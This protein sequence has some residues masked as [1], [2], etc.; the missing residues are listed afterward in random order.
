[1]AH[2]EGKQTSSLSLQPTNVCS[3]KAY[4]G[5]VSS[6]SLICEGIHHKNRSSTSITFRHLDHFRPQH[7]PEL[8]F[9]L[10]T[11]LVPR[12]FSSTIFKVGLVT[13]SHRSPVTAPNKQQNI[14]FVL[15]YPSISNYDLQRG[16][17][18]KVSK[19]KI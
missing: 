2:F 9:R 13:S 8:S 6:K 17:S 3:Y 5:W 1:M 18:A 16:G 12:A 11:N 10:V 15:S 14:I 19:G 7:S 4:G